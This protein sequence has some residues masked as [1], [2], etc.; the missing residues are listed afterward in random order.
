M[1]HAL[2]FVLTW[3][4]SSAPSLNGR[5]RFLYTD[6]ILKMQNKNGAKNSGW[7][8]TLRP[9]S[10][11]SLNL[12]VYLTAWR[13]RVSGRSVWSEKGQSRGRENYEIMVVILILII[14]MSVWQH[15]NNKYY[16]SDIGHNIWG[17]RTNKVFI[18]MFFFL[19]PLIWFLSWKSQTVSCLQHGFP[20]RWES[21]PAS[22][23][24]VRIKM[25]LYA[26]STMLV[27]PRGSLAE[28]LE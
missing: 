20:P 5:A 17:K 24:T 4:V 6:W 3:S 11:A 23:P 18:L 15:W 12:I 28:G 13:W 10:T 27:H 22:L 2:V 14:L 1:F 16:S 7:L 25:L 19:F 8:Q 26:I 9:V 21:T